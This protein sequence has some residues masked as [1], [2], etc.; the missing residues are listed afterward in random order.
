M[1]KT[2]AA[3]GAAVAGAGLMYLL[4]PRMGR[5]RRDFLRDKGLHFS[6]VVGRGVGA[7]GRQIGNGFKGVIARGVFLLKSR[8]LNDN[9]L[10]ERIRSEIGRTI[11][12]A[13]SV[14]VNSKKGYVTLSGTILQPE[15]H[16]LLKRVQK[17]G[18]VRFIDDRLTPRWPMSESILHGPSPVVRTGWLSPKRAFTIASGLGAILFAAKQRSAARTIAAAAG[19]SLITGGIAGTIGGRRKHPIL[20]ELIER[21]RAS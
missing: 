4:D 10:V 1:N 2:Y 21:R 17:I 18:G 20:E 16:P 12:N 15:Y 14:K 13:S 7:T 19:A 3:I 5:R 6:K 8:P 11:A 9:E